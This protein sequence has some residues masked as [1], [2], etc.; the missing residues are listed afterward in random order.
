MAGLA[1]RV[2]RVLRSARREGL[3]PRVAVAVEVDASH[4]HRRHIHAA[5]HRGR[6]ATGISQGPRRLFVE[7]ILLESWTFDFGDGSPLLVQ[8]TDGRDVTVAPHLFRPG[9]WEIVVTVRVS[10]IEATVL[11]IPM[12]ADVGGV[13]RT[14][15]ILRTSTPVE[16]E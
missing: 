3:G 16:V 13:A 4:P 12:I 5:L 1:S 14:E 9:R 8:P 10:G 2:L 6:S 7:S 11:S 15:V